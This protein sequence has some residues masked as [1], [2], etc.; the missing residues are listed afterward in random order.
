MTGGIAGGLKGALGS[1]SSKGRLDV[2]VALIPRRDGTVIV[3]GKQHIM[4]F[5]PAAAKIRWSTYYP[6]PGGNTLGFA[7]MS[8]LT[9][10][11]AASYGVSAV[12]GGMSPWSANSANESN[13]GSLA[14]MAQ[15]RYTA[16]QQTR[17]YAYVLTDVTDG[18]DKGVGLMAISLET[19]APGAQVLLG[20]KEPEYEVDDLTGRLYYFNDH[21]QAVIYQLK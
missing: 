13:F 7:A 18:K 5:D 3:A 12:Q 10:A 6:A 4:D 1:T 16:S 15:K 11:A 8:A 19:G 2:P 17:D 20:D 14:G 9:L 21:K